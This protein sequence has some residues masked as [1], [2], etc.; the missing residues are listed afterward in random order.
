MKLLMLGSGSIKSNFSHRLL[1]LGKALARRGH[2]ISI[3][4]P[5]A[6]KY[7]N[8]TPEDASDI[9]EVRVLQPFQFAT[10][11]IEINLLPYLFD[12]ARLVLREK[13]DLVYIYKPTPISIIGL[14]A[15]LRR[16]PVVLDIDDLGSEVMR[17]EGHPIHQRKL[18][19]W[20]ERLGSRFAS[21]LVVAS[22]YLR[23]KYQKRFPRK[24]IHVLPNGVANDWFSDKAAPYKTPRIVFFGWMNRKNIV[25]PLIDA[26]PALVKKQ[27]WLRVL[28][29][30]DGQYL[31]YFKKKISELKLDKYIEYTG[32]LKLDDGRARLRSGDIGYNYMPDTPTV[33]AACNMKVPQYMAKGVIPL[34]SE[35]GDLPWMV[36]NGRA[37]YI[38]KPDDPADLARVLQK[39]ITDTSRLQKAAAA[40]KYAKRT[41]NWDTLAGGLDNWLVET[42]PANKRLLRRFF[43]HYLTWLTAGLGLLNWL[44]LTGFDRWHLGTAFVGAYMLLA[45]GLVLL[46]FLVSKKM[47]L[48]LGLTASVALSL[49]QLIGIGLLVNTA[50]PLVGTTAP[51]QLHVL[52]PAFDVVVLGLLGLSLW[53]HKRF[54]IVAPKFKALD[55]GLTIGALLMP[56]LAV[57]G[58]TSLNNGGSN[59][60][61]MI[62]LGLIASYIPLLLL[63]KKRLKVEI[64]PM[65]LYCMALALL[66]MS[67][68]R[69][70]FITGH[71]V[72]REYHVYQLAENAKHWNIGVFRDPY[73]A[74]LSLT[75]LPTYINSFLQITDVYIYKFVYQFIVA[76]PVV[77]IF[78]LCRRYVPAIIAF[79]A[80]FAYIS[81]PTFMVDMSMLNRQGVAFV[82]FSLLLFVLLTNHY[83][84]GRRRS[85]LLYMLGAGIIV[86]HYSTSYVAVTMIAVAY[87]LNGFSRWLLGGRFFK[88]GL[89]NRMAAKLPNR[90]MYRRPVLLTLPFAVTMLL[91]LFV[92]NGPITN[93]SRGISTTLQ[94]IATSIT[95]PFIGDKSDAGPTTTTSLISNVSVSRQQLF[96]QF[97][98]NVIKET[99][100]PELE[101]NLFPIE[102]ANELEYAIEVVDE[103]RLA[104][105]WAGQK[106]MRVLPTALGNLY[107]AIKQSYAKLLQLLLLIGLGG[108]ALGLTFHR[109]LDRRPPVEF[110]ALSL[111]GVMLIAFQVAVPQ[112][113]IDYGLLRLFQ[114]NLILLV[115]PITLGILL[116][117]GTVLRKLRAQVAVLGTLLCAVFVVLSG[118]VPQ[119]T[120][121]S[122]PTLQLNNDGFYYDA[123]YTHASEVAGF[124]WLASVADSKHPIQTDR[125]FNGT[126]MQA[127]TGVVPETR[128]LPATIKRNSYVFLG[129]TNVRG[130]DI[131]EYQ[132]ADIIYYKFPINFLENYKNKIYDAGGAVVYQ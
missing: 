20:S 29:I 3:I 90:Q 52:L 71:D 11:R 62:A 44:V 94:R 66:L 91:L 105:G 99:R 76:L 92:W 57:M 39:A 88:K 122:R 86:S 128:L 83:I 124:T 70:W 79:L 49:V 112:A 77:P 34:V 117:L 64:L 24:P 108:L 93:T 8:F 12:A 35:V 82:F 127:Y 131:I 113:G 50:L 63:L 85:T 100:G 97:A 38:A 78:Y 7:N 21:R 22:T 125:Y 75:I 104:E 101:S 47:P 119:L 120:G 121:G 67:S 48:M 111:A 107:E 96:D 69:G 31:P 59:L 26:L 87:V 36:D 98:V 72:L 132:G 116:L 9:T 28:L 130:G 16:I 5:K 6:D 114:Q 81:F 109:L 2:D 53:R 58:A 13:P 115:L 80:G 41:F 42:A 17:I 23:D 37:G 73:N 118:F 84:V 55:H 18:V 129:E 89:I 54:P 74:C 14:V 65:A 10:K 33:R 30:G 25:E 102:V 126:K 1:A 45:P 110:A 56:I 15:R 51:L 123:Y 60:F 103:P 43:G 4:A 95:A 68:M 61:T 40:K 106:L 27:P 46:S 32:G 19:E